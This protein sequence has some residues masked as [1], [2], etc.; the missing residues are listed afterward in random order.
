VSLVDDLQ[1]SPVLVTASP[2]TSGS[3]LKQDTLQIKER[4]NRKTTSTEIHWIYSH[5]FHI[6]A[7]L[8][9]EDTLDQMVDRVVGKL[10]EIVLAVKKGI[11]IS[12]L[13]EDR[14]ILKDA[15]E[16][17]MEKPRGMP[18]QL[19]EIPKIQE[20]RPGIQAHEIRQR[21]L[22]LPENREEKAG[23]RASEPGRAGP[24]KAPERLV[25]HPGRRYEEI[26][27]RPDVQPRTVSTESQK[28]EETTI[29]I[30]SI[31]KLQKEI[32]RD[33]GMFYVLPESLKK[34]KKNI[35]QVRIPKKADINK[36]LAEAKEELKDLDWLYE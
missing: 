23:G 1:I 26:P 33:Q 10:D 17:V 28:H 11:R 21:P 12:A 3:L 31:R 8:H 30:E 9:E 6:Y 27:P 35:E 15:F 18:A 13:G 24:E 22:I 14:Q 2:G 25:P 16:T 36:K 29:V 32:L 34:P 20:T 5:G 4:L 19:Q 7:I